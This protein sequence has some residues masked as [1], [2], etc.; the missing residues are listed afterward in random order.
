M[1]TKR[2]GRKYGEIVPDYRTRYCLPEHRYQLPQNEHDM[3]NICLKM[4]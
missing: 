4:F 1:L 2:T 3:I